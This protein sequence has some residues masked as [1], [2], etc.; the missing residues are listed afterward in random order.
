[1]KKKKKSQHRHNI[2]LQYIVTCIVYEFII[3]TIS[4][5]IYSDTCYN[6]TP[7][8]MSH[9]TNDKNKKLKIKTKMHRNDSNNTRTPRHPR[10]SL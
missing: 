3:N 5:E 1:M 2:V 6:N 9:S 10:N 4:I 7:Y 8:D